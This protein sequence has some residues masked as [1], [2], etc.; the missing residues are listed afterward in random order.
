MCSHTQVQ[1][2]IS[3]RGTD[4]TWELGT[5]DP[6][7]HTVQGHI[8]G[9][10]KGSWQRLPQDQ[11]LSSMHIK[12]I[13]ARQRLAV[14]Y[15]LLLCICTLGQGLP[16]AGD[17]GQQAVGSCSPLWPCTPES[18]CQRACA[19]VVPAQARGGYAVTLDLNHR[20]P[21]CRTMHDL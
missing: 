2:V 3:N 17:L 7:Q 4:S 21:P 19:N 18:T 1:A 16:V 12:C 10:C 8:R 15:V 11:G 9:C 5:G 20:C 6:Y 14:L 13:E